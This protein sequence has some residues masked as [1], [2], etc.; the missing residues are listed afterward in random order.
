MSRQLKGVA[1]GVAEV[2]RHPQAGVPLVLK[3]YLPLQIA[4]G[5]DHLLN[6]IHY[7]GP[8]AA[9]VQQLKELPVPDAAVFDHLGHA[10]GEGAVAEGVETVRIDQ[11]PLGLPEGP[12]QIFSGLKVDGHLAPHGGVH[13]GQQ[14][15]GDLDEVHPPEEGGGGKARQVAHHAAAQGC[16]PVSACHTEGHHFFPQQDQL[17]RTLG[18]LSGGDGAAEDLKARPLQAVRRPL[19]I[20]GQH[21]AVGHHRQLPGPGEQ[22]PTAL[23]RLV[24]QATLDL[25][26]I[27]PAREGHSQRLFHSAS[28]FSLQI[29]PSANRVHSRSPLPCSRA[30]RYSPR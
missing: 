23:P 30:S 15:G 16:H 7:A 18:R 24:Q 26:L 28:T 14:S 22:R 13:L 8:A 5:A 25:D 10:V 2:Q 21:I 4:A 6:V 29:R 17:F 19:Q 20:Q 9:A 3:H 1:D 12:G 11:H 27:F